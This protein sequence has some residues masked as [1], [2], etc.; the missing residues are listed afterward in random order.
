MDDEQEREI[1][2]P[3][4]PGRLQVR[5]GNGKVHNLKLVRFDDS[6][7]EFENLAGFRF[8]QK[9]SIHSQTIKALK[10]WLDQN[11]FHHDDSNEVIVLSHRVIADELAQKKNG[12]V[13]YTEDERD[14]LVVYRRDRE[15]Y[16]CR[17]SP[18]VYS[19]ISGK[20]T[21][22]QRLFVKAKLQGWGLKE[23]T[24]EDLADELGLS[25]EN[26]RNS[27]VQFLT[28]LMERMKDRLP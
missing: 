26:K 25:I 27:M 20:P 22:R 23:S 13:A 28:Y 19:E 5:F 4:K 10:S 24:I 21:N 8:N 9:D 14:P 3:E 2:E 1:H 17:I 12:F 6:K 7:S 16:V 18:M 11:G 15:E